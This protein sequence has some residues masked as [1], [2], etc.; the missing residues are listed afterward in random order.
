MLN[1]LARNSGQ[2]A[3]ASDSQSPARLEHPADLST[4][5]Y[6][7]QVTLNH[8]AGRS[9]GHVQ[10]EKESHATACFDSV[11]YAFSMLTMGGTRPRR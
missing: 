2:P 1:R 9:Q 3:R 11:P 4:I 7:L 10:L 6:H 5:D 8:V